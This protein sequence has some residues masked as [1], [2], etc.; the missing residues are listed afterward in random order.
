MFLVRAAQRDDLPAIQRAAK[1]LDSVNLPNDATRLAEIIERSERSFGEKLEA[2]RREFLFVLVERD[3]KGGEHV[4]GSSMVFA[5]H[6]SRRAPHVYFDVLSEERYSETID[7]HFNHTVLRIGY[8]YQGLTEVGGLV[9]LPAYRGRPERL[10]RL[11]AFVRFLYL[12]LHRAVF[13]DDVVAELMPPLEPDG[14]SL[15]WEAL[16]RRFTGLGYQ[17]ADRLSRE[18]K[19]FI[20]A[21]FPQ[22]PIYASLL[23]APVQAVIGKVGPASRGVEKLLRGIGFAYAHRIDPFDGGPHFQARTDAIALVKATRRAT[24]KKVGG[25]ALR[26]PAL[27]A[28]ESAAPPYFCAAE[29]AVKL[30]PDGV[31]LAEETAATLGVK[32]GDV[33]GCLP[34][35]RR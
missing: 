12:G 35:P 30:T 21:L 2:P 27:V 3:D 5:A 8:N 10:G 33:V 23:P 31:A 16:G 18:N 4:V 1:H 11:I 15:L 17:E 28:A 20:R 7:R 32:A 6:G 13:R 26:T 29:T 24:V 22:D 19:E 34:L 9:L 25:G 14:T